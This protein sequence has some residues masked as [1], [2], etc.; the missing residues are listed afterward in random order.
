MKMFSSLQSSVE[1]I[2][3][4]LRRERFLPPPSGSFLLSHHDSLGEHLPPGV[5]C[6]CLC[7]S[8]LDIQDAP[9]LWLLTFLVSSLHK[10]EPEGASGSK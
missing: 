4:L 9:R 6:L 7:L 8:L 5:L 3:I 2:R 10:T 1:F